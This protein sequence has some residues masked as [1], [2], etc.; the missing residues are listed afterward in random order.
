[1]YI[2]QYSNKDVFDGAGYFFHSIHCNDRK[3]GV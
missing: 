2:L 1:M 3:K